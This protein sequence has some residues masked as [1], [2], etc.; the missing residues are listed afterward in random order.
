MD[1][2]FNP[3]EITPSYITLAILD[4]SGKKKNGISQPSERAVA[5]AKEWVD[6]NEK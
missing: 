5:D 1:M 3:K 6:E 4:R 2:N